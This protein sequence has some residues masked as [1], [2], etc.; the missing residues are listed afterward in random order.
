MDIAAERDT[1]ADTER[2]TD[3]DTAADTETMINSN[4]RNT[5]GQT[6]FSFSN[7]EQQVKE[8]T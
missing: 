8:V 4:Y 3:T 5:A 6:Y 1:A 2:G 7:L